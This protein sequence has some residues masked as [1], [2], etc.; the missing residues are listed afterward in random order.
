MGHLNKRGNPDKYIYIYIIE[1]YTPNFLYI[2]ILFLYS[3]I[4]F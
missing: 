2:N 3:M 4:C 1:K